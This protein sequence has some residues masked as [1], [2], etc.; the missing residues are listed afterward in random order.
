MMCKEQKRSGESKYQLAKDGANH[1]IDR[2]LKKLDTKTE[3]LKE[4]GKRQV[5]NK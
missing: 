2:L 3:K 1:K 5:S 4:N